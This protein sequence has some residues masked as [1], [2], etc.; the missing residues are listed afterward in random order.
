MFR[1]YISLLLLILCLEAAWTQGAIFA[2]PINSGPSCSIDGFRNRVVSE[3]LRLS[4][5]FLGVEEYVTN[6]VDTLVTSEVSGH[7]GKGPTLGELDSVSFKNGTETIYYDTSSNRLVDVLWKE[8]GNRAVD[9]ECIHDLVVANNGQAGTRFAFAALTHGCVKEQPD[10]L[11]ELCALSPYNKTCPTPLDAVSSPTRRSDYPK[12]GECPSFCL[13]PMRFQNSFRQW[14]SDFSSTFSV[15][16]PAFSKLYPGTLLTLQTP[17]NV[18]LSHR[19]N[20]NGLNT[21]FAEVVISL[22][23]ERTTYLYGPASSLAI[24]KANPDHLNVW[25]K[26]HGIF[27]SNGRVGSIMDI[28]SSVYVNDIYVGSLSASVS[29]EEYVQLLEGV[30]LPE[31]GFNFVVEVESATI[32]AASQASYD[33]IFCPSLLCDPDTQTFNGSRFDRSTEFSILPTLHA[34]APSITSLW[35]TTLSKEISQPNGVL[36]YVHIGSGTLDDLSKELIVSW[37]SIDF[38]S[39]ESW[40][41]VHVV[42][43][44]HV[45]EAAVWHLSDS[46]A[47]VEEGSSGS[48]SFSV[49]NHGAED[50]VWMIDSDAPKGSVTTSPSSGTLRSG[51]ERMISVVYSSE[52]SKAPGS[53]AV[54]RLVPNPLT[55]SSS[56]FEVLSFSLTVRERNGGGSSGLTKSELLWITI[57][58]AMLL[59]IT[60]MGGLVFFRIQNSDAEAK[61]SRALL[62]QEQDFVAFTFHELRTPLSGAVGFLEY[63]L[64]AVG[65]LVK[66]QVSTAS[67]KSSSDDEPSETCETTVKCE[68]G[69]RSDATNA[70]NTAT[71]DCVALRG[72]SNP[73]EKGAEPP[74]LLQQAHM[75]LI[76][77]NQCYTHTLD[78]LNHVLDMAKLARNEL[79]LG[80]EPIDIR[81]TCFM[82][83]VM[84]NVGNPNVGL[85]VL[86]EESIPA[87]KGDTKRLKQVCLNLLANALTC[88]HFGYVILQCEVIK[89]DVRFPVANCSN[90][91]PRNKNSSDGGS[92]TVSLR[93]SVYDTGVGVP[94]GMQSKIFSQYE[95]LD[96]KVGTG[97]GLSVCSKLVKLMGGSI[98]VRSPSPVPEALA[99]HARPVNEISDRHSRGHG[100]GSCFYFEVTLPVAEKHLSRTN[101]TSSILKLQPNRSSHNLGLFLDC[102]R[103]SEEEKGEVV[104]EESSQRATP[105]Q[106]SRP[107]GA[108]LSISPSS[109]LHPLAHTSHTSESRLKNVEVLSLP[110]AALVSDF[111]TLT[112]KWQ[113]LIVDDVKLNRQLLR[114]R[115]ERVE[116]F[117]SAQWECQEAVNGENAL[118]MMANV[119]FDLVTMDENMSL[120]NGILTGTETVKEFRSRERLDIQVNK[121]KS[122]KCVIVAVSGNIAASDKIRY[123]EAGM[124]VVWGK[125]LPKAK[126][127]VCDIVSCVHQRAVHALNEEQ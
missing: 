68:N 98:H 47:A 49:S 4:A 87:V 118:E 33:H 38:G 71:N 108:S 103:L 77:A 79:T 82:A 93:F 105:D 123:L 14:F 26:P 22:A 125:P 65:D 73:K 84:Q 75:D 112:Q 92:S 48:L 83:C 20:F 17:G 111:A 90:E 107:Y 78:I 56:C 13:D 44:K 91:A 61:R 27:S 30:V 74:S 99:K 19:P 55:G 62:E 32:V 106:R 35:N 41:L 12:G 63:A 51:E 76:R 15:F 37:A 80:E 95:C 46:L 52:W 97:L 23:G 18:I 7:L 5:Y 59:L 67:P 45:D 85:G 120:T 31:S 100:P 16:V 94:L 64:Q 86:V 119:D 29:S 96:R 127:M 39:S 72:P 102:P 57:T 70:S 66:T 10:T 117:K 69:G 54:L 28:I 42:E 110:E 124:D 58:P 1:C 121:S 21:S 6:T 11:T 3:A 88:T 104:D 9:L 50:V 2:P 101:T 25:N 36:R 116:P 40:V 114:R 43:A 8:W 81:E 53:E 60:C 115:F 126:Q 113:V 34:A 109:R 89:R 122:Q 24:S